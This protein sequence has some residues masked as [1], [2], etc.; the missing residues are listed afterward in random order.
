M[1]G[2]ISAV[3]IDNCYPLSAA[4]KPCAYGTQMVGGAVLHGLSG[5]YE[6]D[7]RPC[8]RFSL[9]RSTRLFGGHFFVK[10]YCWVLEWR[11]IRRKR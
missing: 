3:L 5:L 9:L 1:N 10:A 11:H 6:M 4:E 7:D 8:V 2:V